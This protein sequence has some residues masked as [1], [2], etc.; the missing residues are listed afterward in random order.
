M[1]FSKAIIL[2]IFVCVVASIIGIYYAMNKKFPWDKTILTSLNN[3]IKNNN[4]KNN[5]LV[6]M[7]P[8]ATIS[9]QPHIVAASNV[10]SV[11][12]AMNSG[13]YNTAAPSDIARGI[14]IIPQ[15]YSTSGVDMGILAPNASMYNAKSKQNLSMDSDTKL[16]PSIYNSDTKLTPEQLAQGLTTKGVNANRVRASMNFQR[17]KPTRNAMSR[18][19][20]M[21]NLLRPTPVISVTPGAKHFY[22]SSF[23]QDIVNAIYGEDKNEERAECC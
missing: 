5:N 19:T 13:Q 6:G 2:L 8:T 4:N 21:P 16:M 3:K 15:G 1:S 11:E 17:M 23:R 9:S 10:S 7:Y 20:G 22:D 18:L 14:S 12:A